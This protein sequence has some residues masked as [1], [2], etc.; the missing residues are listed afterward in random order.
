MRLESIAQRTLGL[1]DHRI[2][3]VESW[4][5]GLAVKMEA[6]RRR[7]LPCSV[8]G[9]RQR[10]RDRLAARRWRHVPLW[11]MSVTIVYRPRRVGCVRCGV[12]GG[13][14]DGELLKPSDPF[15]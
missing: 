6:R 8:C 13:A 1:K 10:V 5:Q 9:R 11:G 15:R 14:G 3:A 4:E 7:R 2:A 12:T